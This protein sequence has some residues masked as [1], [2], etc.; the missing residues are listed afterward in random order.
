LWGAGAGAGGEEIDDGGRGDT[1]GGVIGDGE[2]T[3]DGPAPMVITTEA[4]GDVVGY[5]ATAE[6][7]NI[8]TK[9]IGKEMQMRAIL[10]SR[11]RKRWVKSDERESDRCK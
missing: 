1:D 6:R 3:I 11:G 9:S 2:L 10:K 8:A 5:C 4:L 7:K